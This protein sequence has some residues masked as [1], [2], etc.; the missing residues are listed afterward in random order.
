MIYVVPLI[1]PAFLFWRIGALAL[2]VLPDGLRVV[3][4]FSTKS[5]RWEEIDDLEVRYRPF[6]PRLVLRDGSRVPIEALMQYGPDEPFIRR[7]PGLL[8]AT[9]RLKGLIHQK[10]Q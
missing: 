1:F 6:N 4:A 9:R 8:D 10:R 3:N 5:V 2:C 7:D